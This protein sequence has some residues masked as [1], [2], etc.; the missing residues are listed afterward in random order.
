LSFVPEKEKTEDI[1][2]LA[3]QNNGEALR[4]VPDKYK[5]KLLN[6]MSCTGDARL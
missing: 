3:V 5:M 1:I 2:R 4:Y 6:L